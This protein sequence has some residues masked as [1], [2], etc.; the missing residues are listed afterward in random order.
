MRPPRPGFTLIEVIVAIAMTAFIGIVLAATFNTTVNTKVLLDE[1]SMRVRAIDVALSRLAMEIG[2]AYVSDRYDARRYRDY[3]N[4]PTNFIG[5]RD[6]LQFATFSHERLYVDSKESDQQV[7][8]YS[9]KNDERGKRSLL[10]REKVVF[11]EKMDRGGVE[12]V[13]L[14][15]VEGFE[16]A[17]WD[18]TKQSWE[19][20][21]DT[22]RPEKKS[23]L[24]SRVR[25]A[26]I[27]K[28]A[29]GK[30]TRFTTQARPILNVEFPRFQ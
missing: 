10:R 1:E 24:P 9:L 13:L 11:D 7:V 6:R 23:I 19:N 22:R 27:T 3:N 29:D 25:F 14:E 30:E 26:I 17:Y 5:N 20:E 15:N 28:N 21:W 8:E 4:R 2:A 16:L 18:S 12:E